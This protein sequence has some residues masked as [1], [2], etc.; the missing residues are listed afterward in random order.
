ME[1]LEFIEREQLQQIQDLYST[2]TGV[3]VCIIDRDGNHITKDSNCNDFCIKYTKGSEWGA[4]RC[5]KCDIEGKG[6]YFC[7]S[8]LMDFAADIVVDGEIYM[9][10]N[11]SLNLNHPT[12][13]VYDQWITV[14]YIASRQ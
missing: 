3:A 2:A 1:I 7:H 11:D 9:G 8:G 5:H 12:K 10:S 13:V 14:D 4:K 6:V